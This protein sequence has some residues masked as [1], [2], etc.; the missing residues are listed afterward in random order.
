LI[1]SIFLD[2][3]LDLSTCDYDACRY[4]SSRFSFEQQIISFNLIVSDPLR[5]IASVVNIIGATFCFW[6][7][8]N[9]ELTGLG[10]T[11]SAITN[12]S[13]IFIIGILVRI[14][15]DFYK[16]PL[17]AAIIL[18]PGKE[19]FV[20]F[21][22]FLF[23]ELFMS[24]LSNRF[25]F[26]FISTLLIIILLCL[27]GRLSYII[28]FGIIFFSDYL[29]G[30]MQKLNFRLLLTFGCFMVMI[31]G[32]LFGGAI[33]PSD[34]LLEIV[35]DKSSLPGVEFIRANT[36]GYDFFSISIRSILYILYFFFAPFVELFRTLN[37]WADGNIFPYHTISIGIALTYFSYLKEI[38]N[39]KFLHHL[40]IAS[41]LIA[42]VF[43]FVHTRYLWPLF[44]FS[45]YLDLKKNEQQFT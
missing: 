4:I 30:Q 17:A 18:I 7:Y 9:N 2:R 21:S 36:F 13:I 20:L 38:F 34:D 23:I 35:Q 44:A 37:E 27:L 32:S 6:I 40:L 39:N 14:R 16:I 41:V 15:V 43:P 10:F 3:Y 31:F 42:A 19:F 33:N 24:R 45:L 26:Y 5:S 11:L 29:K 25:S 28:F 12:L 1:F 22:G 8:G